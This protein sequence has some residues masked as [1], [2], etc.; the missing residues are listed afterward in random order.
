MD[1]RTIPFSTSL[2]P[3][4]K[5]KGKAQVMMYLGDGKFKCS[6]CGAI[7]DMHS[8]TYKV[9]LEFKKAKDCEYCN[10]GVD[11]GE[12]KCEPSMVVKIL[13]PLFDSRLLTKWDSDD[14]GTIKD[15]L[16]TDLQEYQNEEDYFSEHK[17]GIFDVELL[18]TYF[19]DRY[20]YEE[21]DMNLRIIAEKEVSFVT[22]STS[23]KEKP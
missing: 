2:T 16:K 18:Y 23:P 22:E 5:P 19:L 10:N 17:E 13:E 7:E 8:D 20:E 4:E 12:A 3:V 9:R 21:Y 14:L 15:A 1:T 6:R 11:C